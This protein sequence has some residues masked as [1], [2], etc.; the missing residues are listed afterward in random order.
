VGSTGAGHTDGTRPFQHVE[1]QPS[2]GVGG[3]VH[4]PAQVQADHGGQAGSARLLNA[5]G[6][7]VEPL[8]DAGARAAGVLCG[9][10]R[11]TDVVDVSEVLA[12]RRHH[13]TVISSDRAYLRVLDPRVPVVDC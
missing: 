7:V 4:R 10:A 6:V 8:T 1:Q 5:R 13:G 2:D 11:T 3:V 9:A 12:G